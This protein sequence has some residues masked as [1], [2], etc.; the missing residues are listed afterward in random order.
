MDI[1]YNNKY[2]YTTNYNT[3]SNLERITSC[4]EIIFVLSETCES[5]HI[6]TK[7]QVQ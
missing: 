1:L 7:S 4:L 2:D 3:F 6:I 5:F